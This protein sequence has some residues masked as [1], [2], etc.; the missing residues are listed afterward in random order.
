[1][2]N[3]HWE[4]FEHEADMGVRGFGET[5]EQAFEQTAISLMNVIT[6]IHSIEAHDCIKVS[7]NAEENDLLLLDWLNELVYQMAT[8]RML[9]T[10]FK[11]TIEQHNLTAT[12]CGE[13]ASQKKHKP[14]VEVKGATFTELKVIQDDK[15]QWMA[16]CVVDV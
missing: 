3:P 1:M 15:G 4:H 12:I 2:S 5:L 14:A 16:Q 11:I 7:C 6:D 8:R 9:F 10:S 13:P